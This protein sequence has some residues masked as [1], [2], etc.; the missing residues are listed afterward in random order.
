MSFKQTIF[1]G[2]TP[3]AVAAVILAVRFFALHSDRARAQTNGSAAQTLATPP[4]K[5]MVGSAPGAA[6]ICRAPA[7][8]ARLDRPLV[9]T[10]RR[11]ASGQPL[12]IVAIGS[13]SAAGFRGRSPG[14]RCSP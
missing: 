2:R 12:T 1:A 7:E 3:V 6:A 13:T 4:P 14:G 10:M 11:L 9:H 5:P 8:L